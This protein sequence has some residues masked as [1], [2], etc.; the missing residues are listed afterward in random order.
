[1]FNNQAF[2]LRAFKDINNSPH[3]LLRFRD[4]M[5]RIRNNVKEAN[6][7]VF[8][9]FSFESMMQLF[10]QNMDREYLNNRITDL[11]K[12]LDKT[13][14]NTQAP[15]SE[16]DQLV[17]EK[18][19]N[20]VKM[21]STNDVKEAD[22]ANYDNKLYQKL[23]DRSKTVLPGDDLNSPVALYRYESMTSK[24]LKRNSIISKGGKDKS[25]VLDI[26]SQQLGDDPY[27][28]E[29]DSQKNENSPKFG[30][31]GQPAPGLRI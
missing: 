11:K 9:P 22:L 23:I 19:E 17:R 3:S 14:K 20:F 21:I 18:M 8:V 1:M 4:I 16:I 26:S 12:N 6:N 24:L 2:T 5:R 25:F 27:F 29:N 30:R 15:K 13:V 7:K 28:D 31:K 10:G